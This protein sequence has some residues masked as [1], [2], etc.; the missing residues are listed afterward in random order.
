MRQNKS[1]AIIALGSSKGVVEWWTPG[2]GV[3]GVKIFV[4]S[5]VSD[6]GFY[7][8]YMVTA[9]DNIKIWDSRMLKVL[10]EYPLHRKLNSLELS[11][12]GLLA[13]NYGYKTEVFKDFY[14]SRQTHSYLHYN[15]PNTINN[16]KFTPFEDFLGLGTNKGF[17]CISVPGSGNAS[18][19]TFEI[20]PFE[21]KK[22][23]R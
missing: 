1:N 3:P 9:S 16:M 12:T 13:L 22:Q 20:N 10:H 15:C 19:D 14:V 5:A 8:G 18:Y 23:K 17:S 2:N 11:Q 7:K 21:S 4:G 6:I